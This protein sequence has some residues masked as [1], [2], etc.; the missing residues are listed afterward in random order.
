LGGSQERTIRILFA[1]PQ[2]SGHAGH[3]TR[4]TGR[5]GIDRIAEHDADIPSPILNKPVSEGPKLFA[6]PKDAVMRVPVRL[7]SLEAGMKTQRP[8]LE[9][10]HSHPHCSSQPNRILPSSPSYDLRTPAMQE[11]SEHRGSEKGV[12]DRKGYRASLRAVLDQSLDEP[13]SLRGVVIETGSRLLFF[14]RF[15]AFQ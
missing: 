14:V 3:E 7:E 12:A 15:A 4:L 1:A 13:A 10:L 5:P 6:N 2:H 9:S 8:I 11:C